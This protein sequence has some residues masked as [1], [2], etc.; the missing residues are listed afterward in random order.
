MHRF[1]PQVRHVASGDGLHARIIAHQ[2][3]THRVDSLGHPAQ[4]AA[5]GQFDPHLLSDRAADPDD[6]IAQS[7]LGVE[8]RAA[9]GV[10]ELTQLAEI[11][12]ERAIHDIGRVRTDEC[13]RSGS[14]SGQL[15]CGHREV[16]AGAD[17][18]G[19]RGD[20]QLGEQARDL[21][22]VDLHVVGPLE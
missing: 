15:L 12:G 18:D 20:E 5:V 16:E 17:H 2:K 13:Q 10:A 6:L 22:P 3:A 9:I 4:H 7:R 21:Q 19:S 11:G 1:I 14:R 8:T